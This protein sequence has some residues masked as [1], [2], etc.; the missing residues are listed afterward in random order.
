[1]EIGSDTH[2][3]SVWNLLERVFTQ[4]EIFW[5]LSIGSARLIDL[6]DAETGFHPIWKLSGT[7]VYPK[8]VLIRW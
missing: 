1:M 2:E 4:L 5:K 8:R 7:G 3:R 6:E